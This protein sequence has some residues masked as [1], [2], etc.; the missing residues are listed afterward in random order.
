MTTT[1][2]AR[3]VPTWAREGLVAGMVGA[4]VGG[5]PSTLHA[6]TTG[7]DPLEASLAA[8]SILL[9]H[10]QRRGRL[11]PGAVLAHGTI[12]LAWGL[13]LSRVLS[14]RRPL[15]AGSAAGLAIAGLDLGILGRRIPRVRRLPLGP[16][17]A[18]HAAYGAAVGVT[19]AAI[20]RRHGLDAPT[21]C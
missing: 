4:L 14:R 18:D 20:R 8:G 13:V 7:R 16:Q 1:L 6:L 3:R 9:P 19:L 2:S 12:S 10:E 21:A 17:L 5:V 11:L 15:L